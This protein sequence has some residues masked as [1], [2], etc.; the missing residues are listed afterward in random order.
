MLT[1]YFTKDNTG[2]VIVYYD[3]VVLYLSL[4]NI[5]V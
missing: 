3:K 4:E 1:T 2:E 5:K